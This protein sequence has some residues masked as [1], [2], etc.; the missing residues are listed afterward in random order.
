MLILVSF[1][2][3]L[4]YSFIEGKREAQYFY[5][6]LK[7]TVANSMLFKQDEHKLFTIQRLTVAALVIFLLWGAGIN[8]FNCGIILTCFGACFPFIHDGEYYV[9]R[10][11]LDGIYPKGWFDQ[12]TTSVS[13]MDKF[14]LLNPVSRTTAFVLGCGGIVYEIIK[15][16]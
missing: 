14:S 11:Q 7:S 2:L 1:L 10:H 12:S 4:I 6:K 3:W 5:M 16:W 9:M 15:N 13:L 8:I